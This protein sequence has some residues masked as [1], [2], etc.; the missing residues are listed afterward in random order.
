M[1]ILPAEPSLYPD[2]LFEQIPAVTEG[3]RSWRVLHTKPRQEKSLARQF[4]DAQQPFFLPMVSRRLT[5]RGRSLKSY[6]PLFGGYCFILANEQE[7]LRALTTHRVV[8]V[9]E[10]LD[11]ERL[12]RDLHQV[13]QL[14]ETG[15]PI[16]PEG[17]LVPGTP[18]EIRQGPLTGLSGVILRNGTKRRFVVQVDFIQQG[19]SIE[20]ED[21]MLTPIT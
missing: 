6:L 5:I 18:V 19:A 9:L 10:V 12:W 11:Q 13:H 8:R 3:D 16:T 14:I 7:R 1:P 15:A 2:Q 20:L 17:R 4:R 21:Y